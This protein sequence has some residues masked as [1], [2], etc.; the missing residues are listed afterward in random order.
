MLLQGSSRNRSTSLS[1][2]KKG[3]TLGLVL[4]LL[5]KA[6]SIASGFGI[7]MS[8]SF[9]PRGQR[10]SEHYARYLEQLPSML[11]KKVVVTGASRGLGYVTALSLAK[12]GASLFLL[13]RR[14]A[15]A[16]EAQSEIAEAA[17][18]PAPQLVDCDLLD[19]ESVRGAASTVREGSADGVD[20]LCCNAGIMLQPD[21]ASRDGYDITISTNVLSHFLL[22]KELMPELNKAASLHGEAR[23]ISHS[24]LSGFGPP[25]F[26]PTFF[27]QRGGDLGG[28]G[29]S[30]ERYH[31]SKLANL[32]F[33]SALHDK[34]QTLQSS[35]KALACT[36][37]VC[38]SDMFVHVMSVMRPGRSAD[39]STV[40]SVEDG[41]LPQLKCICDRSVQSGELYTP[42]RGGGDPVK[43]ALAPPSVLVDNESKAKLWHAC[44][45]AVGAF[46][47]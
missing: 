23:I 10:P 26:D 27:A 39:L 16:E 15:R 41:S 25:A 31:Q 22:T 13:N 2:S 21:E 18:G 47:I 33:I 40:P 37:G 42:P 8:G 43:V 14:S 28:Q 35:V 44:E 1:T 3:R 6:L 17:S 5:A 12:K 45:R 36:P 7:A 30:Y 4:L 38:A 11:G 34:L 20:V 9:A 32:L 24:S 46:C 29:A 19:F